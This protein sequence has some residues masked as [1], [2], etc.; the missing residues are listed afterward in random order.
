[1]SESFGMRDGDHHTTDHP[2]PHDPRR[3][4]TRPGQWERTTG[5]GEDHRPT[6]QGQAAPQPPAPHARPPVS[7]LPA[8]HTPDTAGTAGWPAGTG[9]GATEFGAVQPPPG[10]QRRRRMR[11]PAALIAAV[12]VGSALVGGGTASLIGNRDSGGTEQAATPVVGAKTGGGGGTAAIA[13]AVSPSIVEISA[14]T[15]AGRSG[16]SG[17][18]V[19][20]GGEI[21]TNNHVIS[22]ADSVKVTLQDGSS[23]EAEVVGT[24]SAKDLALLSIRGADDLE[25]ATLGD[26][27]GVR[28]G[29]NVL[30]IG[31]PEGL[32][33]TVTSG[34]VSALNRDVTVS[35]DDSPDRRQE[36]GGG[37]WPFEYGG[38]RY[39]GDVGSDKTTY[40]AI[41]TDASLNPGNSGGALINAAGEVIGINSAMYA[42]ASAQSSTAGSVGLGFAIPSNTVKDDLDKLRDSSE[43]DSPA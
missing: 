8:P 39:N 40:Q 14:T 13:K 9:D 17:V 22:G 32:S 11:G 43:G 15:S 5:G 29:D 20:S 42:P 41:Q 38:G 18:V 28:V 37:G 16:G 34:I 30:A 25:A 4:E 24:D 10:G 35:G 12:A 1:M 33:G 19:S 7:E 27:D 6:S 36:R 3:G 26:S 21:V 2:S 31:S 23:K